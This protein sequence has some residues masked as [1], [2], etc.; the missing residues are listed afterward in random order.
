[1][2]KSIKLVIGVMFLTI[3]GLAIAASS[4]IP[5]RLKSYEAEGA[6]G[7]SAAA[8][9][10]MWHRKFDA[11]DGGPQRSCTS[12]HGTDLKKEGS[13]KKTGKVIEPMALSVNPERFTDAAK[14]EKW[15]LRNC[16]WTIGR[17]CTA[18]EKGDAL[19]YLSTL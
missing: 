3:S 1:M 16:K 12:C 7:F 5:E 6:K 14:I 9:D 4:A 2:K 13:H 8:G 19:K 18:Q 10:K 17:E 15:F 11:P